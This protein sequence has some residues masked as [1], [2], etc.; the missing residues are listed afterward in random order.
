M[1][2]AAGP[3]TSRKACPWQ[4]P[5]SRSTCSAPARLSS[6]RWPAKW[7]ISRDLVS[8]LALTPAEADLLR[9]RGAAGNL[10]EAADQLGRSYATVSA[11][12]KGVCSKLA[13][14]DEPARRAH[15]AHDMVKRGALSTSAI[16][17]QQTR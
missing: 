15:G 8:T 9:H 6:R 2:W 4:S 12:L 16:G 5:A 10:R 17:R 7:R 3:G 11:R 14:T 13:S 1:G